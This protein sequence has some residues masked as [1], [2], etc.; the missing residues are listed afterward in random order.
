MIRLLSLRIVSRC[1]CHSE[2]LG[3]PVL[4]LSCLAHGSRQPS[5]E[6]VQFKVTELVQLGR[7]RKEH[8]CWLC[9][10]DKIR[11]VCVCAQWSPT[12]CD[13]MDCSPPGSSGPGMSQ[14]GILECGL[15]FFS[16]RLNPSFLHRQVV[17]LP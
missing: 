14:A 10:R 8:F 9:W 6:G 16:S 5:P 7:E 15:P 12:L 2:P 17:S 4:D 3:R 11:L 13:P 1:D